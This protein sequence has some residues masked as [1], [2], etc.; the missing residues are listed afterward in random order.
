MAFPYRRILN[1]VDF[2]ENSMEAVE[3]ASEFARQNDGTVILLHVIP[4]FPVPRGPLDDATGGLPTYKIAEDEARAKLEEIARKHLQ[5]VENQLLVCLG[6]PAAAILGAATDFVA[7]VIVMATHGRTG[8]SRAFFGSIAEEVLREAPCP[9]LTVHSSTPM[10][11]HILL[12]RYPG[13]R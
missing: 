8:F 5:G 6:N 13:A 12:E 2:D 4:A 1:P 3:A 9:V 10:F 7:D 11:D